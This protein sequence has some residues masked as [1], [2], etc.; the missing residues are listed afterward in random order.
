MNI[1]DEINSN[2]LIKANEAN[3]VEDNR[4]L[5]EAD[6]SEYSHDDLKSDDGDDHDGNS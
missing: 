2:Q 5:I 4:L 1:V 3:V 6:D